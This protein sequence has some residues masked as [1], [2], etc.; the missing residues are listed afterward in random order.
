MVTNCVILR[1]I[2]LR[3]LCLCKMEY[4]LLRALDK[5][6]HYQRKFGRERFEKM[7]KV[8]IPRGKQVE[9]NLSVTRFI[10]YSLLFEIQV[11]KVYRIISSYGGKIRQTT[12]FVYSFDLQL[13]TCVY[14]QLIPQLA[15]AFCSG[16]RKGWS[17]AAISPGCKSSSGEFI[18]NK[19]ELTPPSPG[20][21]SPLGKAIQR[22]LRAR[23]RYAH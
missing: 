18:A 3:L 19:L 22:I 11:L 10:Y 5:T 9:I 6:E 4:C 12:E 2:P 14:M 8:M 15:Q 17:N 16:L 13:T 1:S 21:C 7:E 23:A 20:E